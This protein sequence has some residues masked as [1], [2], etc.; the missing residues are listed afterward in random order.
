M[1]KLLILV[2]YSLFL[3]SILFSIPLTSVS[4]PDLITDGPYIFNV[5]GTLKMKWIINSVLKEET[6]TEEKFSDIKKRFNL[7]CSF[8]DLINTYSLKPDFR[9]TYKKVDSIGV[10]TDVHGEYK[11]YLNL[12]KAMGII[13]KNLNW[14]FGSGHL[15]IA[16]DVFDRG[17][18]VNEL[19]WHLFGLE[20]QAAEA[21]GMVHLLI[22][23]HELMVLSRDLRFISE[24]YKEVERISGTKYF[25]LYS[26]S[27][28]IGNWIRKKPVMITINNLLFV[29]G[30][31]SIE[32]I[33]KNIGI[34]DINEAF[35]NRIIGKD[36]EVVCEDEELLFY[37]SS[38]GPLWYRGYFND[39]T[40][41]ESRLDSI[42]NYYGKKRIIVGHTPGSEISSMYKHKILGTDSGIG[43]MKQG[44][45]LI[46]KYG[47][48]YKGR[49]NGKRI[50][51]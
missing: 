28:V 42:L 1:K 5:N 39:K 23:N 3:N 19:F 9:Q 37:C 30:G 26:D 35:C 43:N 18:M 17:E 20:K 21:G 10:L 14:S 47:I 34:T 33:R 31:I 2:L 45:M 46:I 32:L 29:H 44:E 40:F 12:L 49:S 48:L 38:L 16:G 27:S 36:M 24:K 22:G 8:N 11:V 7:R 4:Y 6:V 15:V 50:K 25:E 51:L 41:C 13:D